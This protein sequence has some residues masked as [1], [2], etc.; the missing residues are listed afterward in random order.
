M[1]RGN[2]LR[3][4][5]DL[6]VLVKPVGVIAS[7][8]LSRYVATKRKCVSWFTTRLSFTGT[9]AR[10]LGENAEEPWSDMQESINEATITTN[11]LLYDL[12]CALVGVA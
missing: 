4:L 7:V 11:L 2:Y 10:T 9:V 1:V 6:P 12:P 8:P 5:R 3:R